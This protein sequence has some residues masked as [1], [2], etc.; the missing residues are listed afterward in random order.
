MALAFEDELS[1]GYSHMR[2]DDPKSL[3]DDYGTYFSQRML[4]VGSRLN[5]MS[6]FGSRKS[7][8]SPEFLFI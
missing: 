7:L 3:N 6:S 8:Y 5:H 4:A 1:L 2:D